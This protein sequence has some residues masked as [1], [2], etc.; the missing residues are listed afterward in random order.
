MTHKLLRWHPMDVLTILS[1]LS[2]AIFCALRSPAQQGAPTA[3]PY[4][5]VL[6]INGHVYTSNPAEPWVEAV[7]IRDGR[8]L[9]AGI[10]EVL[11][12]YRGQNTQV[13]DLA[14]RMAMPGMIDT[15]THFLWGSYGLAGI[16]LYEARNVEEVQKI[17]REYAT[18]HPDE[19]WVY[20]AGWHYGSFWPT[21]L[22]TKELLDLVFPDRPVALMSEDGHS[23]WVNSKAL[24]AAKITRNTPDPG[25]AARGIIVREGKTGE[26]TGVLEEGAKRLVLN[27]MESAVS[28]NEKLRR[29]RLGMTFANQH[30]ITGIVNATG[31]LAEME[32]YQELHKR[33]ELTVRTTTAFAEDVGVR[34]TLSKQELANFEEARRRFHDDWV[35]AGIIKFFADGVI[36]THTAAMLAP[37][38]NTPGQR[39]DTLYT[40]E[41][42]KRYFL[43]LDG[44]GFQVMTHAIGDG[45]VRTTL[46]AYEEVEK[47]HGP[48]DRRWRIEHLETVDAA[49]RPRLGKL[50]VLA[51]IQ[52]WCCPQKGEP[53]ADNVGPERLSEGIPWQ[54]IVSAGAT[55]IMGSDWPVESLDPFPILQMGATRKSTFQKSEEAFFPKQ[56]LTLDQMLAGYTR[57]AAYGEFMEDRLGTLQ[58]GKLADMIV[59]SQDLY[60]VP[61]DSITK[62]KVLLTMVGGKIVWRD[63]I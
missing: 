17:L 28:Q 7:A 51:A 30:G 9:D 25:G 41:E 3:A 46:D 42:F 33:G 19:K 12:K 52:P 48:R 45:A 58:A 23:V 55:L 57:N 11:T 44:L 43:E 22:P 8:I 32:L 29:I 37:Y 56:A 24:A 63:G 60:K 49:D 18:S 59:L 1:L 4:A 2:L 21:G 27:V 10:S 13:I 53:W 35:R 62:T 6:F 26:A 14:G 54:D 39:G 61:P 34:H 15:H 38:A 31:D 20:G 40:P 16:Q 5:D 50:R 36:E 47:Q